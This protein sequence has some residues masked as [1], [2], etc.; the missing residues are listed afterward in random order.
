MNLEAYIHSIKDWPKKGITFKDISPL[1]SNPKAFQLSIKGMSDLIESKEVMVAGI[2]AR[3]FIFASAIA[4][5]LGL[6][7]L[8]LRKP[9]KLPP[10]KVSFQYEL[11][12]G[13][14]EL[15]TKQA[16]KKDSEIVLVDDILATGGT[17]S[18]A[19][20]LCLKAGYAVKQAVVLIDLVKIH[21]ESFILSNGLKVDSL[22]KLD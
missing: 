14:D 12:Y 20:D 16:P 21:S 13:T 3:G 19:C 15:E 2:D 18:A 22:I 1:L 5:K 6:G 10:P 7:M 11:E 8:L 17:I 9:G 4:Q